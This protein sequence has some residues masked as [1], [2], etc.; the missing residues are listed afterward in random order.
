MADWRVV[1]TNN[2]IR[3]EMDMDTGDIR[4]MGKSNV[5]ETAKHERNYNAEN[6]FQ[7]R[8]SQDHMYKIADIP[9]N[10]YWFLHQQGIT[11]DKERFAQWLQSEAGAPYRTDTRAIGRV[12]NG[13]RRMV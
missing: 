6:R 9:E 5:D 3:T 4:T 11:Q 8:S 13:N 1:S 7:K 10:I 12:M 2:G